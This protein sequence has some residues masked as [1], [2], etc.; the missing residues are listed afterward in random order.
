MWTVLDS[1]SHSFDLGLYYWRKR[2][3]TVVEKKKGET[4]KQTLGIGVQEMTDS[5]AHIIVHHTC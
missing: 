4:A 1:R 5:C 2:Y 3:V